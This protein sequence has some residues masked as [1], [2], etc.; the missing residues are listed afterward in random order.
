MSLNDGLKALGA[1]AEPSRAESLRTMLPEP[2][3][4]SGL[5]LEALPPDPPFRGFFSWHKAD[6]LNKLEWF[7]ASLA[8]LSD[9]SRAFGLSHRN[10]MASR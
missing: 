8:S 5:V 6:A 4:A 3:D 2:I 1:D 10:T 9:A 7:A